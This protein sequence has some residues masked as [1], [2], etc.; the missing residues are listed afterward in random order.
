MKTLEIYNA[1][2]VL[3]NSESYQPLK[4]NRGA[5]RFQ[6]SCKRGGSGR[7]YVKVVDVKIEKPCK[8]CL[9]VKTLDQFSLNCMTRDGTRNK[10]ILCSRIKAMQNYHARQEKK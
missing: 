9:E 10:C 4:H 2:V 8:V 5:E 1:P 7:D 6:D 3:I